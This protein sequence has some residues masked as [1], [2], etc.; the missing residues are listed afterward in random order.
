M[1]RPNSHSLELAASSFFTVQDL[2]TRGKEEIRSKVTEVRLTIPTLIRILELAREGIPDDAQ[3][4]IFVEHLMS[5]MYMRGTPLDMEA[6]SEAYAN[7]LVECQELN[8]PALTE[9]SRV[10][11]PDDVDAKVTLSGSKE[12][13]RRVQRLLACIEYNGG[14]GHSGTFGITWDG[15][16][17]DHIRIDG[18]P[19]DIDKKQFEAQS[20]YGGEVEVVGS[21]ESCYVLNSSRDPSHPYL[22]SRRVWPAEE[23]AFVEEAKTRR[24]FTGTAGI[25]V[26]RE[27]TPLSKA[28]AVA[29][30]RS[31]FPSVPINDE[32]IEEQHCTV[33]YSKTCVRNVDT[34]LINSASVT[35]QVTSLEWWE[36]HDKDGYLVAKLVAPELME[37]H[38]FWLSEGAVHSFS[39]YEPHVTLKTPLT[40]TPAFEEELEA[41]NQFLHTFQLDVTLAGE[42]LEDL[43]ASAFE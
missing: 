39:P 32:D 26:S 18:L 34:D 33:V 40:V 1:S 16:G 17:S 2:R 14:V 19:K 21:G 41:A 31:Q 24:P 35:A 13:V 38:K 36:G 28:K 15:D 8:L 37:R 20:N 7:Y 43:K 6:Y 11:K 42:V 5:E 22:K 23:T 25:Y 29:F 9:I 3:L 27:L 30:L 12:C 10:R 4:H